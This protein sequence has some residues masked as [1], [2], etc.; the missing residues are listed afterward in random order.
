VISLSPE[1]E[2]QVDRLIAYSE[3][4]ARH[5]AAIN[6]LDA[7]ERAKQRIAQNPESGL[8]APRPYPTLSR[9]G[10]RWIIEGRYWI[11]CSLTTPPV[12]SG[13]FFAT[14]DISE[15]D[16][17][18]VRRHFRDEHHISGRHLRVPRPIHSDDMPV[19]LP[20]DPD[21]TLDG[22]AFGLGNHVP[23]HLPP[24]SFVQDFD[25]VQFVL[26]L[27]RYKPNAQALQRFRCPSQT[28][29]RTPSTHCIQ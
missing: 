15:P 9:H 21:R 20:G 3:E 16:L 27:I 10:R 24:Q 1:A 8:A 7:L 29:L 6:L 17:A 26:P 22:S 23:R 13:V 5:A 14:A 28:A 11:S 12:I 25:P 19:S 4:K 18:A 2:A